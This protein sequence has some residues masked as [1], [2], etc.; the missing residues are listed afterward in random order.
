MFV[1]RL[2][3]AYKDIHPLPPLRMVWEDNVFVRNFFSSIHQNSLGVLYYN[4]KV[5]NFPVT[6]H[7]LM[8]LIDC[9]AY[10]GVHSPNLMNHLPSKKPYK[11]FQAAMEI[12]GVMRIV[13]EARNGEHI[14][15]YFRDYGNS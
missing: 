5:H 13:Q 2:S 1:S 15:Y 11:V 6:E 9:M 7:H 10:W 3:V 14:H 4:N 12:H 8:G